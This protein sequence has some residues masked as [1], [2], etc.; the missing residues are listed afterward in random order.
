[1]VRTAAPRR[2]QPGARLSVQPAA[3]RDRS[4]NDA[5]PGTGEGRLTDRRHALRSA[6]CAPQNATT[7]PRHNAARPASTPDTV[8]T[9]LGAEAACP[10]PARISTPTAI[11]NCRIRRGICPETA[12][13]ISV[14]V[15]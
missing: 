14:A 2:L 5:D 7:A 12:L 1:A 9:A 11:R 4:G 8:G 10:A 15:K 3:P 13:S 6:K